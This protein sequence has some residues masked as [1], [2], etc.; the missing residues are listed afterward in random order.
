MC[1]KCEWKISSPHTSL[2]KKSV[3]FTFVVTGTS[4]SALCSVL[5]AEGGKVQL[6]VN[7]V[8]CH[9]SSVTLTTAGT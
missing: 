7:G 8:Y 1:R 6:S 9:I 5:A 4:I 2:W 3:T